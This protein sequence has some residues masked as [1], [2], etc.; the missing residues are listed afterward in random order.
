MDSNAETIE[1]VLS[2]GLGINDVDDAGETPLDRVLYQDTYDF[3]LTLGA[4][5]GRR[6]KPPLI[7]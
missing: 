2:L 5:H 6:T 3:L 7:E 4:V 1:Y